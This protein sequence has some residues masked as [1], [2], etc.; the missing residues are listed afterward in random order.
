MDSLAAFEAE[1][2]AL[3]QVLRDSPEVDFERVSNCPPW[4]LAELVIHVAGSIQLG[5]F[6]DAQPGADLKATADYYRRPER[7]TAGYRTDNIR[8]AQDAAARRLASRTAT[9]CFVETFET[10]CGVLAKAD[11]DRVVA[12]DRVGAMRLGDWLTT[13]VISLAAHGVDVA[14]TL[15]RPPWTTT[16]AHQVMR[17]VFAS[18]L[19]VDLPPTWDD[20]HLLSVAT[21]RAKL[22]RSDLVRLGPHARRFPLLS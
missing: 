12:L 17:P 19:S 20:Q 1:G 4:T 7:D 8:Q 16:Q 14:I 15:H 22:S 13:R 18:L 5:E 6:A 21:G 9:D 11:L 3:Q 10:T 2:R